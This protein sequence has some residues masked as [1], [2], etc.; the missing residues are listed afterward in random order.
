[1]PPDDGRSSIGGQP[2]DQ[3]DDAGRARLRAERI[4]IVLQSDNLISF[5]TA[6]E[7]VELAMGFVPGW[8]SPWGS[9]RRGGVFRFRDRR[10]LA[11]AVRVGVLRSAPT[12]T[13][14]PHPPV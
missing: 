4:G 6:K 7:N 14:N 9:A 1:M 13:S 8:R 11:I 12:L 5:L 10:A 2:T 3:L